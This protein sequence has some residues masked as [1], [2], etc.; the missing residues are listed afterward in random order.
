MPLCK[1]GGTIEITFND[2]NSPAPLT[3]VVRELSFAE[4]A[5]LEDD[6]NEHKAKSAKAFADNLESLIGPMI[7][8]WVNGPC[9]YSWEAW[10]QHATRQAFLRLPWMIVGQIGTSEKKA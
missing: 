1:P 10:K 2:D 4:S 8:G 5:Q 7:Q 6:L 9:E 3:F